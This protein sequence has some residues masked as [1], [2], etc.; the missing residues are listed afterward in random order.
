MR[1]TSRDLSSVLAYLYAPVLP[2]LRKIRISRVGARRHNPRDVL[3]PDG[4]TVAAAVALVTLLS[5]LAWLVRWWWTR[6]HD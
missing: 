2:Y 6:R 1:G 5:G 4:F 3:V